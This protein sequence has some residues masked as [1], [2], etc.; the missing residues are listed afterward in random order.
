MN[1]IEFMDSTT[2]DGIQS[3][4]AL[5]LTAAEALAIAPTM[6][7]AGFKVID[8]AGIPGWMYSTRFLKE[9]YWERLRLICGA[10][11]KTPLNMWLR[12]RG[13]TDFTSLPKPH[14]LVKLW[15]KRWCDY[16]IKRVSFI[17]E[18]NDYNNIPELVKY[19][20]A[21]GAKTHAALLY[22]LSPIHTDEYYARKARE[23]VE[24]GTDVIEIKDQCGILTPERV[25]TLIPDVIKSVNGEADLQFQT[26]C[27]TGLGLLCSLEAIKLGIRTIRSCLPPLCEGTSN[28]NTLSIIRNA[29]Y[30]GYTSKLKME[31]ES[32]LT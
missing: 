9:D 29:E 19:V 14:A 15:I 23:A 22:A 28:P 5:R 6:D 17:E 4:W 24:T 12:S 8:Y 3:L 16:G 21:Q 20:Q 25:R 13:V 30:L 7:E 31:A 18:E 27:N 32:D 11:T 10:I 2:R 26:H 1:E